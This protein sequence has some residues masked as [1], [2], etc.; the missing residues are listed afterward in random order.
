VVLEGHVYVTTQPGGMYSLD[1]T[2]GAEQ[3]WTPEAT[4]FVAASNAR[5]Y[6]T[7]KVGRL[8]ILDRKT[9]GRLDSMN[10]VHNPIKVCNTRTDR[11][12][13]ATETGLIQSLHEIELSDPLQHSGRAAPEEEAPADD[14][15]PGEPQ[16]D[17]PPGDDQ[18]APQ[19]DNPFAPGGGEQPA[20]PAE[21]EPADDNPFAAGDDNPFAA[22]D[23]NP[24]D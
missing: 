19:F 15:Q 4:Q 21:E 3:W 16:Q 14:R 1:A 18:P 11:I 13:L 7:D 24:F 23:D 12:Y 6:A 17:D 22:G 20:E 8:L 2:T 10:L 9:G 5:V